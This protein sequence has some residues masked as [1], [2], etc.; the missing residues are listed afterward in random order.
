MAK[1]KTIKA[2]AILKNNWI[3][4]T[5]LDIA[6]NLNGLVQNLSVF[7]DRKI[8][9]KTMKFA[10]EINPNDEYKVLPCTITLNPKKK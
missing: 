5:E 10:K 1:Q 6:A 8:A 7:E 3:N 2:W 4:P 9:I